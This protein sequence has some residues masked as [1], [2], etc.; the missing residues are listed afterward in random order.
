MQVEAWFPVS[1]VSSA[2]PHLP[3]H[4]CVCLLRVQLKVTHD[5]LLCVKLT[6]VEMVVVVVME[7]T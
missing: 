3:S 7:T 1:L 4:V 5:E 6:M 2:F